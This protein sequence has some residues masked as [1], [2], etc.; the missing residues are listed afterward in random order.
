MCNI[1]I[2]KHQSH[3]ENSLKCIMC[4]GGTL[5]VIEKEQFNLLQYAL[6]INIMMMTAAL[7]NVYCNP[8]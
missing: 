5:I 6:L 2:L 4:E 8:R 1:M 3:S 7:S